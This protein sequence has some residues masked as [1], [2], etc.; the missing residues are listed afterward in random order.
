MNSW[1]AE[2][3]DLH[4][5]EGTKLPMNTNASA[6]VVNRTHRVVRERAKTMKEQKNL[7]R[8]LF[9]PLLVCGG[10]LAVLVSA[11][12]SVLDEYE[13]APTGLP[14]ASQ[15]MLVLSLWCL[16]LSAI[17][18]GVVWFRR[19]AATKNGRMQ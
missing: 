16:P 19:S 7:I 2:G 11:L 10:L 8:S 18:L 9:I 12:W 3:R 4:E 1:F 5:L 6:V 13:I 17:L 15:Q 14:D